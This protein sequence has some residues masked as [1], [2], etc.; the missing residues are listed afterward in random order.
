MKTYICILLTTLIATSAFGQTI[1]VEDTF[2]DTDRIGGFDGSSTD[3]SAPLISA[4][5]SSN[6]QW[7]VN[8]TSQM[9]ASASGMLWN[10]NN[11]S[12]R[13]AIG[14]YP[15]FTVSSTPIKLSLSF[16]TG[17]YGLNPNNLR[18]AIFD[19]TPSGIRE[20]DGFSSSDPNY[21]ND[22]GYG[23]FSGSSNVGGG[24]TADLTLRTY[25][26]VDLSNNLLGSS[27]Q[28]SELDRS[29]GATG[30]LE[31]NT[32]YLLEVTLVENA[33]VLSITTSLTGGNLTGY[34]YTVQDSTSPYLDFNAFAMRWGQGELQF[35]DFNLNS[36]TVV[37]VPEPSVFA[38]IAG[39][40]ALGFI[41][42][43]RRK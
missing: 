21:V 15:N 22:V 35:S 34:D 43:R 13:M 5:T 19:A 40:F 24:S 12:N 32:D 42:V 31:E 14:Y 36:F 18:M 28:W 41:F 33:G 7:V 17:T 29:S 3:S 38:A 25:E 20:T 30:Y 16:T 11:T 26:R 2:S 23:I 39:I 8:G 4:P 27:G 1:L 6:T 9:V 37:Q 10:M